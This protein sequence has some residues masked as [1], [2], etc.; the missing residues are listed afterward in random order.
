MKICRF[1]APPLHPWIFLLPFRHTRLRLF[2]PL[3]RQLNDPAV[4]VSTGSRSKEE[5]IAH[6]STEGAEAHRRSQVISQASPIFAPPNSTHRAAALLIRSLL[7][8]FLRRRYKYLTAD[9]S[10]APLKG[11]S[12]RPRKI[13]KAPKNKA[14]KA[15]ALPSTSPQG[16][17][18]PPRQRQ[19]S[20]REKDPAAPAS[21]G[22]L[23]LNQI[24]L[25]VTP[26]TLSRGDSAYA[27]VAAG[28]H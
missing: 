20:R 21:A 23:D 5:E 26:R 3:T 27:C 12:A 8:R 11:K 22:V 4:S 10:P 19:R 1:R 17:E 25:P 7:L 16:E 9:P 2:H 24:S 14:R 18:L 28:P 15:S 13:P 6:G